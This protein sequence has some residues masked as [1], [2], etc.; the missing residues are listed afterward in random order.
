[1]IELFQL[2]L[3]DQSF[4]LKDSSKQLPTHPLDILTLISFI[5]MAPHHRSSLNGRD[6]ADFDE[7]IHKKSY[8]TLRSSLVVLYFYPTMLIE[9]AVYTMAERTKQV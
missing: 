7:F 1:M 4:K 5:Q 8:I 2:T 9:I 3:S 6:I